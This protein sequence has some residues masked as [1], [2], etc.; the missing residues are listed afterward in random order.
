[1][2]FVE[3]PQLRN[4]ESEVLSPAQA[5]RVVSDF[6]KK[7]QTLNGGTGDVPFQGLLPVGLVMMHYSDA[8]EFLARKGYSQERIEAIP[9]AQV[10]LIYQKQE[11]LE[12]MDNFFKWFEIPYYKAQTHLKEAEKRLDDH[13]R[14]KGIKVNLFTTLLPAMSRI[15]FLQ[16]RLDRNIALLRTIEAI[17]MFAAEHSGQLPGSLTEIT[18]VPIPSDPV[19]GKDFIY[20]RVDGRNA[21]LEAPVAP[22]ERKKRPVY[23]LTIKP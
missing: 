18:S 15:A 4:L 20:R 3:F 14:T 19:T 13:H 11:Y 12:I 6:M 21:R 16:A 22:A 8:K 9:A 1:V 17:R 7:I 5:S 2:L 23:E 10:V